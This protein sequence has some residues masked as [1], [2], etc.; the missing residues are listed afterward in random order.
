MMMDCENSTGEIYSALDQL[1]CKTCPEEFA[2][3]AQT[4]SMSN[5][6]LSTGLSDPEMDIVLENQDK[7]GRKVMAQMDE[8][9]TEDETAP[10][11]AIAVYCD[12]QKLFYDENSVTENGFSFFFKDL[13]LKFK[14]DST[15]VLELRTDHPT[16]YME[17][18]VVAQV[19]ISASD[20]TQKFNL[21]DGD[22]FGLGKYDSPIYLELDHSK[23]EVK[24]LKVD[25]RLISY[26]S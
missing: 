12:G 20:G 24:G 11:L 1:S 16:P 9:Q 15:D 7:L 21:V 18:K 26:V 6:A 5:V 14:T 22:V 23:G 3:F 25:M 8:G 17:W 13:Y 4:L 10:E 19:R 2:E